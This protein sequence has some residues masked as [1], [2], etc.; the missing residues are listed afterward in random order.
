MTI[1]GK[2]W[3]EDIEMDEVEIF[4]YQSIVVLN[5]VEK[6]NA[7]DMD[8]VFEVA[9]DLHMDCFVDCFDKYKDIYFDMVRRWK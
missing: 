2:G 5:N 1:F 7:K 3:K 4:E 8:Y 6:E 9:R